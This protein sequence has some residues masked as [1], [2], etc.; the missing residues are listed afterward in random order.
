MAVPSEK[1]AESLDALRQLQAGGRVALRCDALSRTHRERLLRHGLIQKVMRGWYLPSRPDAGAGESTSWY[2]AYWDF[3]AA[4]LSHRF[5]ADWCL[6]PE[7]SVSLHVENWT[8]PQQ[9]LEGFGEVVASPWVLP[10]AICKAL[11]VA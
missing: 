5:G 2:A 1:L 10:G 3:C 7:Q 11:A 4:Y 9:L 8:V 6:S